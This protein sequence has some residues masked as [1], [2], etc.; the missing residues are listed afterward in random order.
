MAT[1]DDT[2]DPVGEL[3]EGIEELEVLAAALGADAQ[4][5]TNEGRVGRMLQRVADRMAG[6]VRAVDKRPAKEGA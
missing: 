6:A 2:R 1:N 3:Y 4:D 5:D